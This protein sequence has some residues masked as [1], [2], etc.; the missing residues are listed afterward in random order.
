MNYFIIKF[1]NFLKNY[2]QV[3][4]LI[5][6]AHFFTQWKGWGVPGAIP[7]PQLMKC[8]CIPEF[9]CRHGVL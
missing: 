8:I 4:K 9:N 5:L 2:N 3:S 7:Y 1:N 6:P